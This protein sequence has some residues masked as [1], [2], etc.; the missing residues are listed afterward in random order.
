[1]LYQA[2]WLCPLSLPFAGIFIISF[3]GCHWLSTPHFSFTC[4]MWIIIVALTVDM[5][6]KWV[7]THKALHTIPGTNKHYWSI[8]YI[9]ANK[10]SPASRPLPHPVLGRLITAPNLE[11]FGRSWQVFFIPCFT[12]K[13]VCGVGWRGRGIFL[14][15]ISLP[16]EKNMGT[17]RTHSHIPTEKSVTY[18][19]G[20]VCSIPC[21]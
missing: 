10:P 11:F 8:C 12:K 7:N 6:L 19:F 3:Y 2:L 4:Q 16:G 17:F 14:F 1:M 20:I 18:N 13:V 21:P 9:K 5:R 15:S